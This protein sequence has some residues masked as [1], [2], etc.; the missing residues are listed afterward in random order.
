MKRILLF[1]FSLAAA[2]VLSLQAGNY[3]NFKS[4]AYVTVQDVNRLLK[5][6]EDSKKLM[7]KMQGM[8]KFASK[9][10]KMLPFMHR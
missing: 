10:G 7:K 2:S 4:V 1:L 9:G 8:A 6:F 5:N 3:K